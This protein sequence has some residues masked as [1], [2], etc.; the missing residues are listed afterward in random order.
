MLKSGLVINF[1]SIKHLLSDTTALNRCAVLDNN[2]NIF[3]KIFS[4]LKWLSQRRSCNLVPSPIFIVWTRIHRRTDL[5]TFIPKKSRRSP[6]QVKILIFRVIDSWNTF[7]T[8]PLQT[9]NLS[10]VHRLWIL[11]LT[12][13][14]I[15]KTKIFNI[16]LLVIGEL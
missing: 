10:M 8:A 5:P 2:Q 3:L 11:Q 4:S 9:A 16:Y 15:I 6:R 1:Y 12:L 14:N 7:P 13:T